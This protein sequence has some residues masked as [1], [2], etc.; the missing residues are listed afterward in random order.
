[1]A[2]GNLS[3]RQKMI[4]MMYLVLLALLAMNVSAEIV[5]AFEN[6]KIK[7]NRSAI[8]AKTNANDFIAAMKAEIDSEENDQ[9]KKDNIGLRDDTLDVVLDSTIAI[10]QLLDKHIAHMEDSIAKRDPVTNTLINKTETEKNLQYWMGSGDQQEENDFRGAGKAYQLHQRLDSYVNWLVEMHNSQIKTGTD[11]AGNNNADQMM[12]LDEELLTVDPKSELLQDGGS[13]TWELYTFEGPVVANT[14]NLEAIKLDIYEKQKKL[15]DRFNERL[16]VATF[17]ADK[18]VALVA[19]EANIVPAGLQFKARLFAVLSSESIAPSFSSGSGS[20]TAEEGNKSVGVLTVGASGGVIPKGK[21]EGV[22]SYSATIR[23]PKATGGFEDLSV[24]G[25]FTVRKP[26]IVVTSAAIQ[27]LYASCGNDVNIDVPALGD[28]YNPRVSATNAEVITNQQ[29]KIK[30]RIV[31]KARTCKVSVSSNTNGQN[32]KIGDLDYKVIQPPK[33]SIDIRV[34][35][36][37]VTGAPV[38]KTSSVQVR[39]VPDE[40]FKSSLPADAR[41]TISTIEVKAQLSL[42]PPQKVNEVNVG[43]ADATRPI[44]VALGTRVRQARPGTTV[45]I[46]VNDIYRVNFANQRIKDTRFSEIE[47]TI[48]LVVR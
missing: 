11:S 4:N 18:V 20:I 35:G 48:S 30:F 46:V 23:V 47:K 42:G 2:S 29:S 13:K 27:I 36:Q 43:G 7:L 17:K 28:N 9:G 1:M 10:I 34:N 22:Q 21:N 6:I 33:P 45:Y 40:D 32:I 5:N 39:L 41:Y 15:L 24:E 14:A 26:E 44:A 31:P 37:R 12:V 38:P 19:P 8:E 25:Q 3:P 16:G